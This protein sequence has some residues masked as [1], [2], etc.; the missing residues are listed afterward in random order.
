MQW[1][2]IFCIH[3]RG[4]YRIKLTECGD[5]PYNA[6]MRKSLRLDIEKVKQIREAKGLTMQDA[7]RS[8]K[9][10]TKQAWWNIENNTNGRITLATLERIA[11]ALGIEPE[12]L[13]TRR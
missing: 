5:A 7:A 10:K 8:S 1:Y 6:A 11:D 3:A 12:Q 13:L 4:K 9:L 2:K